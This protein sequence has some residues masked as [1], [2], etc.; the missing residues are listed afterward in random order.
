[1]LSL[2]PEA[3]L[4]IAVTTVAVTGAVTGVTV[5]ALRLLRRRSAAARMTL[6]LVGAVA[7]IAASTLAIGWEMYLSAHD[8]AVLTAVIGISALLS[9]LAAWFLIRATVR[10]SVARIVQVT[11]RVGNGDVLAEA[12]STGG[13]EVD[14]VTTELAETSRRL[15]EARAQVSELDRARQQFF[16]WISHD[17]RTPLAGMRAMAE[18]LEEGTAP[19][20]EEYVRRIRTKVD[21]VTQMVDDL[22]QLSKLQTGT[23]ELHP[24]SVDLLD[25]VS[26]SV[27]DVQLIAAARGVTLAPDGVAGHTVWADPRELTRAIGNLLANSIRHAP[28]DS[29]VL[30]RADMLDDG[31]LV[32][33]V[34]DQ[35][36][37][38]TAE[39]FGRMF[40]VGWRADAARGGSPDESA[41]AHAGLGLAIVRG[42]VEA[43]GGVVRAAHTAAG[44]QLDLVLPAPSRV[45]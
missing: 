17:L 27:A 12:S 33:S 31:R 4:L 3:M 34:I 11:R 22:F 23:L 1:M 35:G 18:S 37:G 16:A 8:L 20:P 40:D 38:V 19:D 44:F 10:S 26:D 45:S 24:E 43:H 7:S 5:L 13:P 32:L 29:E 30:I 14:A 41:S 21:T 2:T 36:P 42:I 25:L 28:R 6:V 9:T 39:D 15:A